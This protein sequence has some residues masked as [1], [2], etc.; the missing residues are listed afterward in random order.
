MSRF[1]LPASFKQASQSH[2]VHEQAQQYASSVAHASPQ[3]FFVPVHYEANYRYPLIVWLHSDGF[4]ENQIN[5]VMPHISTRNYLATGVRGTRAADSVGHRFDWHSSPASVDAAHEKVMCAIEEISDR[6]SVHSGRIILAGYRSGG[7]MAM[8]IAF[9]EPGS[10]A[11]VASFGGLLPREGGALSN[12]NQVRERRLP[13]LW[14]VAA[15]SDR[16]S[17]AEL[18]Q[19][20]G[21][22]LMLQAKV[23]VR[24][25][26]NDDEMNTAALSDFNHWMMNRIVAGRPFE[27]EHCETSEVCFSVN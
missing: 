21:S 11:A 24:Q 15:F 23:E 22:A 20:I 26:Q 1:E 2:A 9:R 13:M 4:N 25:Y 8:R 10:F 14:Q 17:N 27:A 12:L 19:D 3:T 5:H 7:T 18:K 6:Y 16:Y